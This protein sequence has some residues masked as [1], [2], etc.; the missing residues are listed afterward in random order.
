[1]HGD[2]RSIG[3]GKLGNFFD[4]G[5]Y[6]YADKMFNPLLGIEI[7]ANY[8]TISGGAQYF[9]DVYDI[10]YVDKTKITDDLFF[11]GRA[12]GI[13]MNLIL[14]FS[15]LYKKYSQK[16]NISGYFGAGFQQYNSALFEK[17]ADGSVNELIDFG[18]NPARNNKNEAASIYLSGQFGIKRKI[19]S[20]LDLE[21]RTG[22][23]FNNEDHLDATISN[24]QDW[25]TFF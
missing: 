8:F 21:F 2:L 18:S 12:Y 24:K 7:R 11:D 3:T 19:N 9:S 15:N 6:V 25:E 14:S 1:M 20:R 22:I 10:L 17:L 13:E 16:W 5:G 23:Y 4:F